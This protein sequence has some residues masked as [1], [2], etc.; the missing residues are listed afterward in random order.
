MVAAMTIIVPKEVLSDIYDVLSSYDQKPKMERNLFT[1]WFSKGYLFHYSV[2]LNGLLFSCR[3]P[4]VCY[5]YFK[6]ERKTVPIEKVD[7]INGKLSEMCSRFSE[8][9]LFW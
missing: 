5:T 7:E 6:N 2:E 9:R 3:E 1:D 4:F 8:L